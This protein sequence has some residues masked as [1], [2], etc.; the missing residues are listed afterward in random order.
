M[1][2]A[3]VI[4][5]GGVGA[6]VG[7][8]GNKVL[9]SVGGEPI[10]THCVRTAL[11]VDDAI[12][13]LVV[14]P[15]DRDAMT[16]AVQ[17]VLGDREVRLVTG[18]V[19]RHDSEWNALQALEVEIASG[20]VDVVA[21]HDAARPLAPAELF[22]RT[23]EAA[24]EHG[25]AIPAQELPDLV[26]VDGRPVGLGLAVQTPQ[27]FAAK[28]L[29]AAYLQADHDGFAGTD[30]ASCVARYTDT[31]IVAVPGSPANLKV[32]FAEDV[33]VAEQIRIG[34]RRG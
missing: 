34:L 28:P 24:R 10:V 25:G 2:A 30:T 27:A 17:P 1:T 6:R 21:L 32:T 14:R 16:A 5:A 8:A 19:L 11:E 31:E 18:G 23:I 20:E 3:I 22:T 7:A 13:V 29:L 12:V 33:A 9:L 26:D 4:L 15:E